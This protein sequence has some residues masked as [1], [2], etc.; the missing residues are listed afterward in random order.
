MKLMGADIRPNQQ[1]TTFFALESM[2][3][4][5]SKKQQHF[6]ALTFYDRTSRISGFLW[7]GAME[8]AATL[9]ENTVVKVKGLSAMFN[10]SMIINVEQIRE[11]DRDEVDMRD[12]VDVV[13]GG[14]HLW[15]E[16]LNKAVATIRDVN[17]SR[18]I[19]AFLGDTK[20]IE[21]FTTAPAGLTV[22]HNYLGG[23]LEH[24]TSTME[25][26]SLFAD[27]HQ[28]LLDRDLL[29]TG[30]FLHD[31]GKTR[32]INWEIS[33]EYSPE[34][35]LLGHVIIGILLLE[36]KISHISPFP[37]D[38]SL[39]LKHMILSHHGELE[40]GSPVRPA[41]PEALA[42]HLVENSDA[43]VNHLYCHLRNTDPDSEWSEY[44]KY[45]GTSIYQKTYKRSVSSG[46]AAGVAA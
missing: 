40:F 21:E 25:L 17:C 35:R 31:I 39:L 23:L 6:L 20:F 9:K 43:K 24:T 46:R 11:A 27:R 32:E 4:R 18:L 1:V 28:G 5:K 45:L 42:L 26:L 33:K 10:G 44:D 8:T 13:P 7:E 37:G 2:L 36:E 30:A 14:I 12:F 3:L 19:E 38:L 34:G 15:Q 16:R 22:H 29:L 41:T